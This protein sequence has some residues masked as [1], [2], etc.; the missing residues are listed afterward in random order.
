MRFVDSVCFLLT[1]LLMCCLLGLYSADASKTNSNDDN[2]N[3][4]YTLRMMRNIILMIII[5][6]TATLPLLSEETCRL[7][8]VPLPPLL[9]PQY[10]TDHRNA[11][12][13]LCAASFFLF[14]LPFS[15]LCHL[16]PP[17][18]Q[19]HPPCPSQLALTLLAVS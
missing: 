8:H 11:N 9:F 7:P 14:S 3:S 2:S 6:L 16:C 4:S 18:P 12:I 5:P 1:F 19:P 13:D 15:H 17:H 10:W